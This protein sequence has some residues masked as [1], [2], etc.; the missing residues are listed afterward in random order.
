MRVA[1]AGLPTCAGW[2]TDTAI[3]DSVVVVVVLALSISVWRSVELDIAVCTKNTLLQLLS[4]LFH[5][6]L[7]CDLAIGKYL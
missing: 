2:S 4:L 7:E 1:R 3:A 5:D 6:V